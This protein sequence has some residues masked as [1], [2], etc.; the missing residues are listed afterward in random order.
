MTVWISL[1]LAVLVAGGAGLL[2]G[3]AMARKSHLE[4]LALVRR[5][6]AKRLEELSALQ[7]LTMTL[8]ETLVPDH[9]VGE[10][11]AFLRGFVHAD[12]VIVALAPEDSASFQITVADGC[13]AALADAERP[14][15]DAG[16]LAEALRENRIAISHPEEGQQAELVCG[17]GVRI[18]AVAPLETHGTV[19]GVV[20]AVRDGPEP[21]TSGDIRQLVTVASHTAMALG[22]ASSVEMLKR[23]KEQWEATFD[24][25][26]TGIAVVDEKCRIRRANKTL[27]AMLQLPVTTVIG[28]NLAD[29]LP[30]DSMLLVEYLD[31]V[32]NGE[33][34]PPLTHH[35]TDPE[36]RFLITASCMAGASALWVVVQIEDVTERDMIEEQLIQ[37]EKMATVG[38]LVSGVAHDLN[39]PIT[40][41]AGLSD[42]LVN[43]GSSV[44]E[45]LEHLKLINAQAERAAHIVRNLLTFAR[46]DPV[47]TGYVDVNEIARRSAALTN[48]D[49]K[50]R[51]VDFELKLTADLPAIIGNSHE[52]QQVVLNL[53]TN[54]IQAVAENPDDRERRITLST[55]LLEEHVTIEVA[56]SGPGIDEKI[57]P[58]IFLPFVT[59]KPAGHGT[60]L[61]L[62][63]AYRIVQAHKGNVEA[64]SLPGG[65]S[66]TVSLPIGTPEHR[67][68]V[69]EIGGKPAHEPA[70]P[71]GRL[72]ILVLDED[73]AVQRSLRLSFTA[74]GHSVDATRDGSQALSL[75][76]QNRYDLIVADAG[77]SNATGTAF[78]EA[79]K[80]AW[81]DFRSRTILLTADVRPETDVWLR[82]LGCRYLRKPF[83]PAD[84]RAAAGDLLSRAARTET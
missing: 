41:I 54:A 29:E 63:I 84:L 37:S 38:Q 43:R 46:K 25:L 65:A 59:T 6:L 67:D 13:V 34:P 33:D 44:P 39:N 80:T 52:L 77:A 68:G 70:V 74:D 18:A 12:G 49:M 31:S 71:D 56:D 27:G 78:A 81:P 36:R 45:D 69:P 9:I 76:Q 15:E 24:V 22:H 32:R 28:T 47:E 73:P 48:Y 20:A 26:S 2:C 17:F 42:L 40:S 66:F 75:L 19:R 3:R 5:D 8:S 23:G 55:T 72:S 10:I 35:S 53:L 57:F 16:L 51:H 83:D 60:G 64:R 61:G 62:S 4:D 82:S 11:S 79:L 50:L 14:R 21:F 30:G 7:Q 58:H 1:G